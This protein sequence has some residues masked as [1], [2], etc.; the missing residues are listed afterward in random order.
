M[1]AATSVHRRRTRRWT[2]EV[3][4]IP[5]AALAFEG[6]GLRSAAVTSGDCR[7]TIPLLA[8]DYPEITALVGEATEV[9]LR[10]ETMERRLMRQWCAPAAAIVTVELQVSGRFCCGSMILASR[11]ETRATLDEYSGL[12]PGSQTSR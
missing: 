12:T 3:T 11:G 5:F 7:R 10:H 9:R 4:P 2:L 6:V 8:T 1:A